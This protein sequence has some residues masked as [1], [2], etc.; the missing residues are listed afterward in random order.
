M[1]RRGTEA[2]MQRK[3]CHYALVRFT[4]VKIEGVYYWHLADIAKA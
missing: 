4:D 1:A 2:T 3:S